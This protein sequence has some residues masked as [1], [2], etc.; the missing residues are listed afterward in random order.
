MALYTMHAHNVHIQFVFFFFL[1]AYRT[2][3]LFLVNKTSPRYVTMFSYPS[4]A[5][6]VGCYLYTRTCLFLTTPTP[7]H[8]APRLQNGNFCRPLTKDCIL[9][10]QALRH[11][12]NKVSRFLFENK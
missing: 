10:V 9:V 12:Q 8:A 11:K 6:F 1:E 3:F 2:F 4:T 5:V 7:D